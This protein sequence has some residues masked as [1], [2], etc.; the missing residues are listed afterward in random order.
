MLADDGGGGGLPP[1]YTVPV[2]AVLVSEPQGK[3]PNSWQGGRIHLVHPAS[4]L[5]RHAWK[6]P[7]D[8]QSSQEPNSGLSSECD[9]DWKN[10]NLPPE[11]SFSCGRS[12]GDEPGSGHD[13][14]IIGGKREDYGPSP[15]C[16]APKDEINLHQE[17][18]VVPCRSQGGSRLCEWKVSSETDHMSCPVR[19]VL[20]FSARA[21]VSYGLS[22]Q[23]KSWFAHGRDCVFVKT[24]Q[25]QCR[26]S[27]GGRRSFRG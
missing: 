6:I 18:G 22:I 15:V 11:R 25:D 10:S 27:R 26:G 4:K 19:M 7:A 20:L 14:E 24:N 8:H 9:E 1:V 3:G 2:Q 12:G 17:L 13:F 21:G 5:G 16:D 23:P